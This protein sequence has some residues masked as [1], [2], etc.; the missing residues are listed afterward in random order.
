MGKATGIQQAKN[1]DRLYATSCCLSK[2]EKWGNPTGFHQP[3][4]EKKGE[5]QR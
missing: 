1:E 5:F 3:K 2:N 4:N